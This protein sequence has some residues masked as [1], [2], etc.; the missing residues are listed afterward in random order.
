MDQL[1]GLPTGSLVAVGSTL[2]RGYPISLQTR[3]QDAGSDHFSLGVYGQR[4]TV[5]GEGTR[6]F[7]VRSA[8]STELGELGAT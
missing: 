2:G 1:A 6:R 4:G 5:G 7:H 8:S 3:V